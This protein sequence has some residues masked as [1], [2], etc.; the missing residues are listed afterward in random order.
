MTI[1]F[2][3]NLWDIFMSSK[4]QSDFSLENQE[5][6]LVLIPEYFYIFTHQTCSLLFA[7]DSGITEEDLC[8]A[9]VT[10]P[11]H[12]RRILEN[13]PRNWT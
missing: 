6:I 9:G 3:E 11:S 4:Q 12:R 13:L 2:K 7:S 8:A 10:N 1:G 5:E